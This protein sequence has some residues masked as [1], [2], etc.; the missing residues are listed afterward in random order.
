MEDSL[1]IGSSEQ[2]A[3]FKYMIDSRTDFIFLENY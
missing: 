2:C 1:F 3:L